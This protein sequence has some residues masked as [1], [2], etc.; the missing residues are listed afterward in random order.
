MIVMVML[1]YDF[2]KSFIFDLCF[3]IGNLI[4]ML[5][6]QKSPSVDSKKRLI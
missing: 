6:I 5:I 3:A 2:K 1:L 4:L